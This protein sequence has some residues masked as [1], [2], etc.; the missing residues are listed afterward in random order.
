M[1]G[2]VYPGRRAFLS[3]AVAASVNLPLYAME[4]NTPEEVQFD[5]SF[6]SMGS[7]IPLDL[8]R[9]SRGASATPGTFRTRIFVNDQIQMTE[10]VTFREREDKTVEPCLS[11]ALLAQLPLKLPEHALTTDCVDLRALIPQATLVFDSSEQ[12]LMIGVPQVYVDRMPRGAV[13]PSAWENGI[14]AALLGYNFNAY[15]MDGYH[16][17]YRSLFSSLNGG[18]NLGSWYFRHT[19]NW[20][21]SS[22]TGGDYQDNNTYVQRDIP[23]IKGRIRAGV[24]HT[25]GRLFD[26]L[27]FTGLMLESD[28]RM[29]PSSRRGYAPE[30]RGIAR[31]NAKVTIRQNGAVL[32]ETTV[33]PGEF[34]IDDLYPTGYGGDLDVVVREADGGEQTFKVPFSSVS[35]LL[36]PGLSRY[37]FAGG[38]L[39]VPSL[40]NDPML[41]QGTWQYGL[42]NRLTV[43]G[44]LQGSEHYMAGQLGGAFSTPAGAFS[45]DV[46]HARADLG[47][48]SRDGRSVSGESY[49][50]SYSKNITQTQSNFSLAAYRFSTEHY[51]DYLTAMQTRDVLD[52]GYGNDTIRRTKSRYTLMANQGLADWGQ[53]YISASV[54]NYWNASGTDKQYQVGYNNMWNRMTYGVSAARSYDQTGKKQDTIMLTVSLP[55][56]SQPGAPTGRMNYTDNS[57]GRSA[58][59]AGVSGSAGSEN[60]MNYGLSATTA[61][62][63]TGNSMAANGQYRTPVTTLSGSLGAGKHYTTASLGLSGTVIGHRESVTFTPYQGDTF[64]LVEAKGAEGA[65]V[66]GYSGI[67]VDRFGYAAVPYL[68]PYQMNE[69]AIDLAGTDAGVELD[70]TAQKVAPKDLAIVKLSYSARQGRPV[71]IT[72]THRGEPV[73]FG[74][75]ARDENNTVVGYVGQGGQIYARVEKDSGTL[76]VAWGRNEDQQCKVPYNLQPVNKKTRGTPLQEFRAVCGQ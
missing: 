45:M 47:D 41:L 67:Y 26:T 71:L 13:P 27:P 14:P 9:F 20:S 62:S 11:P 8:T 7:D 56:G 15:N 49:R 73:P 39:N 23:Q 21:W 1:Q 72:A 61:D 40:K 25:S 53:L 6:L 12:A 42:S 68:N 51:M 38:E 64:A 36:R 59:Q 58:W 55:L 76:K 69:V 2:L 52:R 17:S 65:R 74:A 29:E 5:P 31:T 22:M 75:E 70:N 50:L 44:G 60:Q 37:E 3:L 33:S 18:V 54:Q 24:T 16:T 57:D 35:Q 66:S 4:K 10:E 28:D 34:V 46:T 32:Y 30:V 43:S 48:R 19:G 63:G